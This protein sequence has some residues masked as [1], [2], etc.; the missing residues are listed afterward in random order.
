MR[1]PRWLLVLLVGVM[2]C[3]G[4]KAPTAPTPPPIA[5]VSGT[6]TGTFEFLTSQSAAVTVGLAQTAGTI[7]GNYAI[8][9]MGATGSIT[10]TIDASSFT[11][12]VSIT[13]PSTTGG[14][15]N[16]SGALNGPASSA[17]STLRWTGPGFL[18][19]NCTGMPLGIAFVLQKR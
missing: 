3:G 11:G 18:T 6:W 7:S 2:A 16:G 5:Q 17:A 14:I 15:C 10:G 4:D 1:Y 12:T 13:L 8:V 19:A 9:S